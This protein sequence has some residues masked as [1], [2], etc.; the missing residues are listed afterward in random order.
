[1]HQA[2]LH[3]PVASL[4]D[5]L[6][7][8]YTLNRDK[9]VDL[10][11]RKPFTDLLEAFGNPHLA[12][13]PVIHVAGTN[14]KGSTIAYMRSILELSGK[15]VHVYTSPHLRR[16]NERIRL[17][18]REIS[19]LQLE[20]LLDE[21]IA[22]NNNG[23]VTFFEITTALALAAFSRTPGD[24]LL[25]ETGLGGRLDC[26]NVVEKPLACVITTISYDHTEFLGESIGEIA[27]EKA[28]IIKKGVPVVL[29]YQIVEGETV[30]GV[31]SGK[32]RTT[33]AEVHAAGEDWGCVRE[34][35]G[36]RFTFQKTSIELPL[37]TLAG[38]HQIGNAGAALAALKVAGLLPQNARVTAEGLRKA[39]W[40]GRLQKIEGGP[41]GGIIP[42]G[43]QV[44][45]DGGHNDSA[46]MV[47]A[48][49]VEKWKSQDGLPAY[50]IFGMLAKKNP[51]LFLKALLPVLDGAYAVRIPSAAFECLNPDGFD[52]FAGGIIKA[53]PGN[54]A[55]DWLEAFFAEKEGPGR[56]LICG[57][58]YLAGD[59]LEGYLS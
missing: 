59:V 55:G 38:E 49:Q 43:W 6:Q 33:G 5:K 57:S 2:D 39:V 22:L 18:G 29:G 46:A 52:G 50:M 4:E 15:R 11:F 40:P 20:A 44:Y 14:G 30:K 23:K 34:G 51:E 17:A 41:L 26:T 10:G 12:L 58:I 37:P 13:P 32:A 19:D 36:I 9:S 25:L 16:F 1:M 24:V 53:L 3:H 48:R 7:Y 28:G 8:I 56:L 21:A 54:E 27:S 35:Q 45:V 31:I 42:S 47:L